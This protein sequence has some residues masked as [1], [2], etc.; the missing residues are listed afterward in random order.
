MILT[1]PCDKLMS[2]Q[3]S[4]ARVSPS[5]VQGSRNRFGGPPL[6]GGGVKS[7]TMQIQSF[8]LCVSDYF[9]FYIAHLIQECHNSKLSIFQK[10]TLNVLKVL[11]YTVK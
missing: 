4:P 5:P 10:S 2:F 7:R 3:H 1:V 8:L 11:T 6:G 9:Q